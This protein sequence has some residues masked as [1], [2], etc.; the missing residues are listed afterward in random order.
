MLARIFATFA[1]LFAFATP[2]FAEVK[3][4][5]VDFQRALNEVAEG[6][7]ARAR[8]ESMYS[9]KKAAIE[10]MGKDLEAKGLEFQKQAVILSDAARKQKEEE[11]YAEQM[12]F[13]SAYQ[14]SE[15]EMQQAYMGAMETLI[16]KMRTLAGTIGQEKGYTLV[17][18]INEGGVVWA[19][20]SV[21]I[22]AELIKRYNAANPAK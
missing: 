7:S 22:T 5:T 14:R 1:F 17:V 21:D 8:L 18:E 16:S 3:I 15:G 4:A 13:Q 9:E 20:S 10:K 6:A 19:S 12:R 2:A 11:L